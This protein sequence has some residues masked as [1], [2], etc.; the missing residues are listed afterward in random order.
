MI[1]SNRSQ[2]SHNAWKF[3]D[4]NKALDHEDNGVENRNRIRIL[5]VEANDNKQIE[6]SAAAS[7]IENVLVNDNFNI[8]GHTINPEVKDL[9]SK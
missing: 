7:E 3:D 9:G 5:I 4:E 1:D 6:A 2:I 8:I